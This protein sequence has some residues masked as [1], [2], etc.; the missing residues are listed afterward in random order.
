MGHGL[1]VRYASWSAVGSAAPH[2]FRRPVDVLR[3]SWRTNTTPLQDVFGSLRLRLP[4]GGESGAADAGLRRASLHRT[5]RR[6][7]V[8]RRQRAIKYYIH[9]W[10]LLSLLICAPAMG[11]VIHRVHLGAWRGLFRH[12]IMAT[13][14][15][16][17]VA[18][19]PRARV[20]KSAASCYEIPRHATR[21]E[22][23]EEWRGESCRLPCLGVATGN[24]G[25]SWGVGWVW[26]QPAR[27]LA[28]RRL[29]GLRAP[30]W[31]GGLARSASRK[32]EYPRRQ[33]HT[34]LRQ[35]QSPLTA[36][37][38]TCPRRHRRSGAG[39]SALRGFGRALRRC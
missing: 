26:R 35:E 21:S 17:K 5:P 33:T 9:S 10:L 2:R 38:Q 34:N 31:S 1:R 25:S 8:G 14:W 7:R 12:E 23:V 13:F 3:A 16:E 36:A 4:G 29:Y 19:R 32:S 6:C 20:L 30:S 22:V 28:C 39:G 18:V 15:S 27:P 24:F 11:L 37:A